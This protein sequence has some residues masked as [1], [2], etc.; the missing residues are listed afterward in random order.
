MAAP[1]LRLKSLTPGLEN[2]RVWKSVNL[3]IKHVMFD[4]ILGG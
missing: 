3:Y 4:N 1:R 2:I